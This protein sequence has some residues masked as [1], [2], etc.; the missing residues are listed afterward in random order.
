MG[1][2][3]KETG[4]SLSSPGTSPDPG[5]PIRRWWEA[6]S[7]LRR[8]AVA[9]GS[10]SAWWATASSIS[11]SIEVPG[12]SACCSAV[13]NPSATA[14]RRT[15]CSTSVSAIR[16]ERSESRTVNRAAN[17][18]QATLAAK[19]PTTMRTEEVVRRMCRAYR[20]GHPGGWKQLAFVCPNWGGNRT[21]IRVKRLG[22]VVEGTPSR[23]RRE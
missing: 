6:R 17:A 16:A 19:R 22:Q 7:A 3:S 12:G 1:E 11:G 13:A 2:T 23:R 10:S 20:H 15:G 18:H 8:A 14:S 5:A 4:P 21:P 9:R